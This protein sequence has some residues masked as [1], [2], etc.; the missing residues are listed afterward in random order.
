METRDQA[1]SFPL[2]S[3]EWCQR[4]GRGTLLIEISFSYCRGRL[5]LACSFLSM[6]CRSWCLVNLM[7]VFWVEPCLSDLCLVFAA[8]IL[9]KIILVEK[10][11]ELKP[12]FQLFGLGPLSWIWIYFIADVFS[13]GSIWDKDEILLWWLRFNVIHGQSKLLIKWDNFVSLR[14]CYF[15]LHMLSCWLTLDVAIFF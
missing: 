7:V 2:S 4:R 5:F 10:V 11:L 6:G 13:S 15:F 14:G 8:I 3:Y 9:G 12:L 1:L